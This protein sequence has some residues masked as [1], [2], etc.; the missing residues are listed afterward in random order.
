MAATRCPKCN[1]KQLPDYERCNHCGEVR[2]QP[3]P[4][5]DE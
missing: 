1:A 2:E 4:K 5:K 3:K